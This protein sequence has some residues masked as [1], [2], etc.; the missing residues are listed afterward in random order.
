MLPQVAEN[1]IATYEPTPNTHVLHSVYLAELYRGLDTLTETL[2]NLENNRIQLFDIPV[3]ENVSDLSS[4][5][6]PILSQRG[7]PE[8]RASRDAC[9]QAVMRP[10]LKLAQ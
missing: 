10:L 3:C 4:F 5:S 6:M 1:M 7:T 2:W 8:P 9:V